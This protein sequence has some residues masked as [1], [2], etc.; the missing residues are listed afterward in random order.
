MAGIGS[1]E[2]GAEAC[3]PLL[4]PA[5][6]RYFSLIDSHRRLLRDRRRVSAFHQAIRSVGKEGSIVLDLGAGTGIL[7]LF[8]VGAG[9]RR[10]YLVEEN[11]NILERAR[12]MLAPIAAMAELIFLPKPLH[13][14]NRRDIDI[15]PDVVM[16]ETI[17]S[18]AFNEAIHENFR[19]ASTFMAPNCRTIPQYLS[20]KCAS[21]RF[22]G[23]LIA[24][25]GKTTCLLI[26]AD[27]D[28]L[29]LTSEPVHLI[30]LDLSSFE[31]REQA[32]FINTPVK[33]GASGLVFFFEAILGD[34]IKLSSWPPRYDCSWG[35]VVLAMPRLPERLSIHASYKN[36]RT[37]DDGETG[38]S[39]EGDQARRLLLS[40]RQVIRS[41][42]TVTTDIEIISEE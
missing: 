33:A 24:N 23:S 19:E 15:P 20:L 22:G 38:V 5:V 9:A 25:N 37:A 18:L 42:M 10:I 28:S 32:G 36:M 40:L 2:C 16:S 13:E 29:V 26:K 14:L 35:L 8:A 21:C 34:H 41:G 7:S 39:I 31:A 30:G 6:A 17:G 11:Q 27:R 4:E 3:S 1:F 12:K